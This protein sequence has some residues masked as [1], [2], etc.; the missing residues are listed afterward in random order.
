MA[1]DVGS[2]FG[3]V[4]QEPAMRQGLQELNSDFTFDIV[5]NMGF[6][7]PRMGNLMGVFHN[8]RHVCTI[9]RGQIPEYDVYGVVTLPNGG[10]ERGPCVKAGWRSAFQKIVNK[11]IPGVTWESLCRKF[12]V[13][14]K[15]FVGKPEEL[16][17]WQPSSA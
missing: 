10:K 5:G 1:I 12:G 4:M 9:S 8:Q 14:Y 15:H 2:D 3:H 13:E 16:E 11:R 7:H 6:I 17:P